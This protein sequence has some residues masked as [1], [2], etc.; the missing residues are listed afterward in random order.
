[1][2]TTEGRR[3]F[4]TS[5]VVSRSRAC[6]CSTCSALG[7]LPLRAGIAFGV[8]AGVGGS[9]VAVGVGAGVAWQSAVA[10]VRRLAQRSV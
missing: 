9:G 5:T 7:A 8:G 1:M 6:V 4:T 2:C 3:T 10:R